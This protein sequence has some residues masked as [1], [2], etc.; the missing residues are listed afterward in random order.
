MDLL[1]TWRRITAGLQT[2][3]PLARFMAKKMRAACLL[4]LQPRDL[5]GGDRQKMST[6]AV[7]PCSSID[8][9]IGPVLLRF[10]GLE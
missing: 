6:G 9:R 7:F 2:A 3:E 5:R 10:P 4:C 8:I 1:F